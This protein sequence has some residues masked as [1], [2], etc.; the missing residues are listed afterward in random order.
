MRADAVIQ[1]PLMTPSSQTGTT[2]TLQASDHGTVIEFNNSASITV[3]LPN[4]LFVGFNCM[5]RQIGS[6]RVTLSAGSGAT[7]GTS[8][9][10]LVTR[11]LW[12]EAN[13]SVRANSS[14][15]AAAYVAS[16]DLAA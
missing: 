1:Y 10:G 12:S 9:F 7:V 5:V 11:T 16:G 3:T 13:V 14:G 6:G 4:S 8:A 15:S 2:Y